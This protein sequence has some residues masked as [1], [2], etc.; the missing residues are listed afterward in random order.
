MD[1]LPNQ[2]LYVN[3]LN[4]KVSLN[5]DFRLDVVVFEAILKFSKSLSKS[6]SQDVLT[7]FFPHTKL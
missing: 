5:V 7:F 3:N 6:L 1:I 4:D 2:T